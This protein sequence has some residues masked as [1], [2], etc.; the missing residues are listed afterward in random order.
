MP[1]RSGDWTRL[2]NRDS[3]SSERVALELAR[4]AEKVR[5]STE[6]SGLSDVWRWR[7]T[8]RALPSG[9]VVIGALV[10]LDQCLHPNRV[11]LAVAVA[12]HG[13]GAAAGLDNHI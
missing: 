2:R 4:R 11:S 7:I 12:S 13:G 1:A 8:P 9:A 10:L 5:S 6:A 3:A